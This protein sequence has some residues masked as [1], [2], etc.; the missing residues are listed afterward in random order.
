MAGI[1]N[2]NND[3]AHGTLYFS[4][5]V[6]SEDSSEHVQMCNLAGVHNVLLYIVSLAEHPLRRLAR[7]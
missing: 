1:E 6:L 4:H 2:R 7:A 3:Q 5:N